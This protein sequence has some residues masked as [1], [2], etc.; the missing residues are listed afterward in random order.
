MTSNVGHQCVFPETD[1]IT[2][3]K[4]YV[5]RGRLL[6]HIKLC[7]SVQDNF[8]QYVK[9]VD[10]ADKPKISKKRKQLI[11]N[12]PSPSS[13]PPVSSSLGSVVQSETK[14]PSLESKKYKKDDSVDSVIKDL[15]NT[16]KIMSS[17]INNIGNRLR[18]VEKKDKK[19]CIACWEYESSFALQPCGHKLL[20]GTCAATMLHSHPQCPFCR[21]KVTDIIQIWD[22][23]M[24]ENDNEIELI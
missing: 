2:C 16:I 17:Q 9:V 13:L 21:T 22:V 6:N 4:I 8:E 19:L 7:H 20:C 15:Q 11:L 12:P 1:D 14:S 5:Q 3:D 10:I 24:N 18:A 23:A